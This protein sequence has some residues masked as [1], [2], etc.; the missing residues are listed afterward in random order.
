MLCGQILTLL[1]RLLCRMASAPRLRPLFASLLVLPFLLYLL[2]AKTSGFES[3]ASD[4][5]EITDRICKCLDDRMTGFK[6]G[7]VLIMPKLASAMRAGGN[8]PATGKSWKTKTFC[9]GKTLWPARRE[10][11]GGS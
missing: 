5:S 7:D 11:P 1:A 8:P 2:A 4:L 6:E 3:E 10:A 9:Q